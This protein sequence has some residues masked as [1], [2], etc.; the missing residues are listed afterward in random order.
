MDNHIY[1]LS[2]DLKKSLD[3]DPRII[4]LNELSDRCNNLQDNYTQTIALCNDLKQALLR[5]AF[6]GEL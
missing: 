5:K 1:E 6:S 2:L 4:K 3:N